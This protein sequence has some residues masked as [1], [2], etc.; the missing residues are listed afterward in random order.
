MTKNLSLLIIILLATA[1][2]KMHAQII[3][4]DSPPGY[5]YVYI[6]QEIAKGTEGSPFLDDWQHANI[7]LKNGKT[8]ADLMVR[9]N[10]QTNQML[11]QENDETYVIGAPDSISEIKFLNKTFIYA[12]YAQGKKTEKSFFEILLNDKTDLHLSS[13][14]Y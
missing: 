12:E 1:N 14:D 7:N 2:I 9:Y 5:N 11:Y 3:Q 13:S 4:V 8:I 6:G 10:V